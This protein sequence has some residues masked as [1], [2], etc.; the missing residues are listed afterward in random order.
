[1]PIESLI[2]GWS[3]ER[4]F[5]LEGFKAMTR[6]FSPYQWN[7]FNLNPLRDILEKHVDFEALRRGHPTKRFVSATNVRT[8]KARDFHTDEVRVDVV[9]ASA[10]L[11]TLF[12]AVEIDGDP[13]WGRRLH[14]QS[15]PL[16]AHLPDAGARHH[17]RP[18]QSHRAARYA[19]AAARDREPD[20]RDHLQLLADQG[21][22]EANWKD[23]GRRS[24]VDVAGEFLWVRGSC[25]FRP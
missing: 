19:A 9:L 20:A 24:T 14:G 12:Q 15:R 10:C 16:S 5:M 25:R 3:P 1:M 17:H 4:S 8:G 13:Y 6:L 7:P 23:A 11:P 22:L 21:T 2:P 18:R